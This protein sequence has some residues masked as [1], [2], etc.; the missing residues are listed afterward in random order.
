MFKPL[1]RAHLEIGREGTSQLA[2]PYLLPPPSPRSLHILERLL[3]WKRI[4]KTFL[5]RI[6]FS[7][8]FVSEAFEDKLKRAKQKH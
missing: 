2:A 3:L 4:S 5:L 1:G 7:S 8:N 6:S